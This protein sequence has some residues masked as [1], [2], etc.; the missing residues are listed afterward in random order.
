VG[1]FKTNIKIAPIYINPPQFIRRVVARDAK[2]IFFTDKTLYI[3]EN[4]RFFTFFTMG[5]SRYRYFH[6]YLG[7]GDSMGIVKIK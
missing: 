1:A 2:P 5:G 3:R 4:K 7:R 6:A